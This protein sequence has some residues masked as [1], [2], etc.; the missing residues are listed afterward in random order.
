MVLCYTALDVVRERMHLDTLESRHVDGIFLI[1]SAEPPYER[2]KRSSVPV[3][4]LDR[5]VEGQFSVA[6]DNLLGGWLAARHLVALGHRRIAVLAGQITYNSRTPSAS[7]EAL[8]EMAVAEGVNVRE[9]LQGFTAVLKEQPGMELP[10]ILTGPEQAVD[11]GYQVGR[12]LKDS[13]HAPTAI[14]ATN[15]IVAVGAW[16]SLLE[17]GVR[18]PQD[19]SL[20]G[21]DDIEMTRLLLPPLTTIAQDKVAMASEA[22]SLLLEVLEQDSPGPKKPPQIVRIPPRLVVRGSTGPPRSVKAVSRSA[23]RPTR[24]LAKGSATA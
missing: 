4:C 5:V 13:R 19:M 11:L 10:Q 9:R 3:V 7:F 22:T 12:L 15:D 6:T 2:L 14:F 23:V 8:G 18:I 20:I 1:H 21:Y 16:R 17:L 24:K